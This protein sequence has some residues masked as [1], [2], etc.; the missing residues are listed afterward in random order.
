MAKSQTTLRDE[1]H[2]MTR[3]ALIKWSVAAGAALGVSRAKVF[4]ILEKTAGKG[5]AMAA[6]ENPPTRSG[7]MCAG[8][9]A[10]A[11]FTLFWPQVDIAKANNPN[12]AWHKQ[13]QQ[14]DVA[15]TNNPLV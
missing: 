4:E 15:G 2:Q 6:A 12:F 11:G 1:R 3:R 7:H 9:G 5:V 14:M 10:L 8:N 13:G